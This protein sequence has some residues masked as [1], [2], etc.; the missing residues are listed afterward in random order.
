MAGLELPAYLGQQEEQKKTEKPAL[1][2]T[3]KP[4][5]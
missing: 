3:E 1:P 2:D 4:K 5:K